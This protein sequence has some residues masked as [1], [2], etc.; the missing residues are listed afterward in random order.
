M[1]NSWDG[2]DKHEGPHFTL[3]VFPDGK[4]ILTTPDDVE[5]DQFESIQTMM[6]QWVADKANRPLF[7][8]KCVVQVMA[9]PLHEFNV[10]PGSMQA[11]NFARPGEA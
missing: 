4:A 6:R 11:D 9:L 5:P 10:V 1:Q 2:D 8:G 3:T 7:I